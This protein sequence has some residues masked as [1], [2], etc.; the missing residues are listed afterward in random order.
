MVAAVEDGE[1]QFPAFPFKPYDIQLQF[2][3]AVYRALQ[4]G[5]V[6]IVESPTG[7]FSS[8]LPLFFFSSLCELLRPCPWR[9]DGLYVLNHL[10]ESGGNE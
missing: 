10:L 1:L 9:H 6:A 3:R 8:P 4:K 2:M 5:G 7:A